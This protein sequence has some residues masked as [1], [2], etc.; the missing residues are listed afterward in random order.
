MKL[1]QSFL[2]K[3]P[4][5][6]SGRT[7][8]VQ[9]LMLHSIGVNQPDAKVL[10]KSWNDSEYNAA[11]VHA[12]I[13]ANDGTVYQ[14]LP[15]NHRGWH[16]ARSGNNTHI[17]VEMCE[18]KGIK[19]Y[20]G[21]S[22]FEVIG[23]VSEVSKQVQTT[24]DAAVEL[25]AYLCELYKLD[26]LKPGVIVSHHEGYLHGIASNHG[27]PEHLWTKSTLGLPY[28]M[29]LFRQAVVNELKNRQNG[30]TSSYPVTPFKIQVSI[31]DLWIRNGPGLAYAKA[32]PDNPFTGIGVFTIVETSGRFGKLKS[33]VG[34]VNLEN[35]GVKIL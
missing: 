5:Y 13:D 33:G 35:P 23:T 28:T 1:V 2:T 18:P 34:W 6:T 14:T 26:P 19:Y 7:I 10:L 31:S 16:C 24:Y 32:D 30:S 20:R 8:K 3:N 4:C 27:D 15:W 11:C 25:F 17:G 21:S 29:N 9:G 22:K 12:F